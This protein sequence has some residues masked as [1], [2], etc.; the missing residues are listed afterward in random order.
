MDFKP[1]LLWVKPQHIKII[2][3]TFLAWF[4]LKVESLLSAAMEKKWHYKKPEKIFSI[5]H[6]MIQM[7][8]AEKE[9]FL[10]W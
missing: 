5:Y 10:K 9:S 2:Q 8:R 6:A 1:I 3:L 7:R 4:G